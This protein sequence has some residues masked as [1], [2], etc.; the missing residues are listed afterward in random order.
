M[1]IDA[2][3]ALICLL[4]GWFNGQPA[5]RVKGGGAIWTGYAN[6]YMIA[7]MDTVRMWPLS[8]S[9]QANNT[10]K[11][12]MRYMQQV[13]DFPFLGSKYNNVDVRAA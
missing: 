8:I 9:Y 6:G 12:D 1:F 3:I 7:W 5:D 11:Q 13:G 2:L 4:S 10:H